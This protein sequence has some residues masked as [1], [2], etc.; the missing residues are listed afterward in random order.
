MMVLINH[1]EHEEKRI[2]MRVAALLFDCSS[3]QIAFF[4]ILPFFVNFVPFV[5]QTLFFD[6]S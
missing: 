6:K 2:R 4:L 1:E 3:K 5:V